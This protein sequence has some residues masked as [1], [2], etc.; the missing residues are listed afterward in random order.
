MRVLRT[1]GGSITKGPIVFSH[2]EQYILLAQGSGILV[3]SARTARLLHRIESNLGSSHHEPIISLALHP[4]V[5]SQ[6]FSVS[7]DGVLCL[8][9]YGAAKLLHCLKVPHRV[10]SLATAECLSSLFIACSV[11]T[12]VKKSG[13]GAPVL[14][15]DVANVQQKDPF[16]IV[17]ETGLGTATMALSADGKRLLC[18]RH[19]G[20]LFWDLEIDAERKNLISIELGYEPIRLALHPTESIAFWTNGTGSIFSKKL[21]SSTASVPASKMHWHAHA[22]LTLTVSPDGNYLLSGGEEGVIVCWKLDSN[23]RQFI[24]HLGANVLRVASNRSGNTFAALLRSNSLVLISPGSLEIVARYDALN[25]TSGSKIGLVRDAR[26]PSAVLVN[27][28]PGVLQSFDPLRDISLSRD[29]DVCE[30]NLIGKGNK[31]PIFS[32]VYVVAF[33]PDSRWMATYDRR[34]T[35]ERRLQHD[36]LRFWRLKHGTYEAYSSIDSPHGAP[37]Q[38]LVFAPSRVNGAYQC[39][40]VGND[41]KVKVWRSSGKRLL[42]IRLDRSVADHSAWICIGSIGYREASCNATAFS[43]DASL[44]AIAFGSSSRLYD[45]ASLRYLATVST[46]GGSGQIDSVLF[47]GDH[48]VAI[49]AR[50]VY[51]RD[52]ARLSLIWVLRIPCSSGSLKLLPDGESF[53]VVVSSSTVLIFQPSSSVPIHGYKHS[54]PIYDIEFVSLE[55]RTT[56]ILALLDENNKLSLVSVTEHVKLPVA[57]EVQAYQDKQEQVIIELASNPVINPDERPAPAA[58]NQKIRPSKPMLPRVSTEMLLL[59]EVPSHYLP[60]TIDAFDHFVK[61]MFPSIPSN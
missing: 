18:A 3:F 36:V 14:R 57:A 42:G 2:D 16:R 45:T 7:A 61:Y 12:Q 10:A 38:Q 27:S 54:S 53:A 60:S 44:M 6:V 11:S 22:A 30:Q 49:D 1:I 8:W 48:L 21:A 40:S 41:C 43:S 33:S 47:C 46:I 35:E 13:K 52:L 39:L 58:F 20:L 59:S 55:W 29:I 15:L 9:H 37:I 24:P 56:P 32:D 51:T 25:T 17:L 4:T 5:P 19:N 50:G 28:V 34:M 26:H 23:Q 31:A